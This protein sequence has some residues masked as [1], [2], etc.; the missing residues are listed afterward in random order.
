M[1]DTITYKKTKSITN[2]LLFIFIIIYLF[3][4][5]FIYASNDDEYDPSS[6][7]SISK[8]TTNLFMPLSEGQIQNNTDKI[9]SNI[10]F[11]MKDE[12]TVEYYAYPIIFLIGRYSYIYLIVYSL[13]FSFIE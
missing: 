1:N 8:S 5:D 7:S 13:F 11:Q 3:S 9:S 6:S 12:Y 4:F 2:K 10:T